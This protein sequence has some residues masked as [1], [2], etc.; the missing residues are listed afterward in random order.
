M[1]VVKGS[2]LL[3]G[4][5]VLVLPAVWAQ[6]A[7]EG[8][9]QAAADQHAMS[10]VPCT[11][12]GAR[13]KPDGSLD[14]EGTVK[15]LKSLGFR[16]TVFVISG[17]G[18]WESFK[19]LAAAADAG[20][21]DV[22]PVLIPPSEGAS[23]LPYRSNY[24]SWME[25]LARES[26][27][28][29]HLR[30]ANIDDVDQ[31]NSPETF[32]RDYV[33]KIYQAKQKINPKLQFV[34]TIYDLDTE[35]ADRLAGCVDG[36]W[37]WWVNLEKAT[38]LPSFLENSKLAVRGRFPIYGGVYALRT[39]WHKAAN[40]VPKV[41]EETL[42]DTCAHADGAVIYLLQLEETNPL[43]AI[44]KTFTAG[45]TSPYADKCGMEGQPNKSAHH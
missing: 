33:C 16:C 14:P 21:I 29:P 31:G 10:S 18:S 32:T 27:R 22:W 12:S 40:P 19:K 11:W 4:M 23:S 9:P 30:G 34:P 25:A 13:S 28:Y 15:N 7:S 39:S 37:L 35:T 1:T 36:V 24:V 20:G 42:E 2:L 5:T 44:T 3:I 38:G 43:L 45:G 6:E 17:E 26:L 41:F 8:V